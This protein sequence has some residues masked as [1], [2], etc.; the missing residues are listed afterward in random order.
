MTGLYF[1]LG[2]RDFEVT[3]QWHIISLFRRTIRAERWLPRNRWWGYSD[4]G[5]EAMFKSFPASSVTYMVTAILRTQLPNGPE[6]FRFDRVCSLTY[7]WE[8]GTQ[9]PAPQLWCLR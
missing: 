2:L 8:G 3:I 1:Q 9:S 5:I 6:T 4:A 7:R